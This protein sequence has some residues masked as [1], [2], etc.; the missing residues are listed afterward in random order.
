MVLQT[1]LLTSIFLIAG[2]ACSEKKSFDSTGVPKA[3]LPASC[4]SEDLGVTQLKLLSSGLSRSASEHTIRYEISLISCRDGKSLSLNGKEVRFDL[5]ASMK[6]FAAPISYTL[7][8]IETGAV[9]TE[10]RMRSEKGKDLFGHEGEFAHWVSDGFSIASS[11]PALII[12]FHVLA[13]IS[14]FEKKDLIIDSYLKIDEFAT[15]SQ[16][17]AVTD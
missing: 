11:V 1:R 14:P 16:P 13:S 6:P 4:Q 5:N 2:L 17:I 15:V 7:T 10:G 3:A 8:S 12:E 9:L